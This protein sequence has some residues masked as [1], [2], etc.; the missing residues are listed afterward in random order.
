[1]IQWKWYLK[2]LSQMSLGEIAYRISTELRNWPLRAGIR[3]GWVDSGGR[4]EYRIHNWVRG[5][6][7]TDEAIVRREADAILTGNFQLLALS[8][9]DTEWPPEWNRDPVTGIRGPLSFGRKIS[10]RDAT[11]VGNVK[12]VWELNRHLE[13]PRL[14][15]AYSLTG[16][17]KYLT[18][19]T[20]AWR[21]WLLQCPFPNGINWNSPLELGIRLINWAIAICIIDSAGAEPFGRDHEL[22]KIVARSIY[23]HQKFIAR[24]FSRHSSANN[25]LIGEAAGLYVASVTWPWWRQSAAWRAQSR[26]I[27]IEQCELQIAEDGSGMEQALAY[28]YFIIEFFLIAAAA[29]RDLPGQFPEATWARIKSAISFGAAMHDCAGHSVNFGDADDALVIRLCGETVSGQRSIIQTMYE[30]MQTNR[31]LASYDKIENQRSS[32]LLSSD[33]FRT[34]GRQGKN[35]HPPASLGY[36]DNNSLPVSV[37]RSFKNGG[38]YILGERVGEQAEIRCTIDCGSLGFRS[39]AAHGHA[40]ALSIVLSAAGKEILID[41]GTYAYHTDSDWRDYFRGTSAHNTLRIDGQNQSDIGGNFMWTRHANAVCDRWEENPDGQFFRGYHDG[42]KKL[43]DPV[44]HTRELRYHIGLGWFEI[45]DL[46]ECN[47]NHTVEQFWHFHPDCKVESLN[48]GNL[49]IFCGS[50][51]VRMEAAD[52]KQLREQIYKGSVEPISGW[53]SPRFGEKLPSTTVC[54]RRAVSKRTTLRTNIRIEI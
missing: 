18:G 36:A 29:G 38:Y 1:M 34:A 51:K 47:D 19:L 5:S 4:Q 6:V 8:S 22:R 2:R 52:S 12:Y 41:P 43:R 3:A 44:V 42:F 28:L 21:S 23:Q 14:A 26:R 32:L 25:H 9:L 15:Q 27:L 10:Y 24:N 20:R 13:F 35:T 54:W 30:D 31:R 50:V 33:E 11:E 46:I 49:Q 45:S 37:R 53:Y 16:D 48:S 39:I 7:K 17:V 40:D